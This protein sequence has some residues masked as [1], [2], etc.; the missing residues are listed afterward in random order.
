[1]TPLAAEALARLA[2]REERTDEDD[3]V[4]PVPPATSS[5]APPST[6][7]TRRR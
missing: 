4:F 1:M 2:Q 3:L 6:V 5:T 7:A